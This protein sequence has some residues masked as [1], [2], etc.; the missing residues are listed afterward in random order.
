MSID[1]LFSDRS[2]PL[3][4]ISNE[5]KSLRFFRGYVR[6]PLTTSGTRREPDPR[7]LCGDTSDSDSDD[8][9]SDLDSCTSSS[10]A[11]KTS[12]GVL[13]SSLR[14]EREPSTEKSFVDD[15][16]ILQS[17]CKKQ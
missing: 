6:F 11:E 3:R 10:A 4:P 17:D 7:H 15:D 5:D 2:I 1:I 16:Y 9:D 14:E 8:S 12:S 13:P